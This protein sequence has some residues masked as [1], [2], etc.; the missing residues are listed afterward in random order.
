VIGPSLAT[1]LVTT[2]LAA[3][4]TGD[5]RHRRRLAKIAEIEGA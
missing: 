4:F 2:F 1:D 3:R 5:E